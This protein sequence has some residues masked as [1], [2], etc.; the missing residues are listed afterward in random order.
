MNLGQRWERRRPERTRDADRELPEDCLLT[1][2][3]RIQCAKG[4]VEIETN[5]VGVQVRDTQTLLEGGS[6]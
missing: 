4:T 3:G 6:F 2:N 5:D 1:C